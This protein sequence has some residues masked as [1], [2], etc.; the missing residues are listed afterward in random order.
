MKYNY[1]Y[2]YIYICYVYIDSPDNKLIRY[3][4]YIFKLI[5]IIVVCLHSKKCAQIRAQISKIFPNLIPPLHMGPGCAQTL[6][7]KAT[8]KGTDIYRV[9]PKVCL[10]YNK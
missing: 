7:L 3:T 8:G 1:I 5:P 10:F 2:I 4:L 6:R 9:K